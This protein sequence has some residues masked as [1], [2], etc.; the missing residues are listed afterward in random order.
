MIQVWFTPGKGRSKPCPLCGES[1][2]KRALDMS[3]AE[4]ETRV[5]VPAPARHLMEVHGLTEV[6]NWQVWNHPGDFEN[7]LDFLVFEK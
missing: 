3:L 6:T 5:H 4:V 2:W 1:D 7:L